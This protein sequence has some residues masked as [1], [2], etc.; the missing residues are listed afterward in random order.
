MPA[1]IDIDS[2]LPPD[3]LLARLRAAVGGEVPLVMLPTSDPDRPLRGWVDAPRF[4]VRLQTP[5]GNAFTAVCRG[6]VAAQGTGSRLQAEFGWPVPTVLVSG[7]WLL[8]LTCAGLSAPRAKLM[9]VLGFLAVGVAIAGVGRL[10]AH[11]EARLIGERM[12]RIAE[13]PAGVTAA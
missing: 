9:P 2:P 12:H 5:Y 4:T 6:T 3:E 8:G 13:A 7:A 10:L 11:R 1:S